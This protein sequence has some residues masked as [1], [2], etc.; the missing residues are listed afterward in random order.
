[1]RRRAFIA[2]LCAVATLGETRAEKKAR[3]R[4]GVLTTTSDTDPEL[5]PTLLA[6][7]DEVIE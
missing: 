4:L 7:A 2:L 3:R 1:V 6:R 5:Q